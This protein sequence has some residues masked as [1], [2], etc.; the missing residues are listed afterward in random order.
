MSPVPDHPSEPGE[1]ALRLADVLDA[2]LVIDLTAAE[3]SQQ[4]FELA[5]RRLQE[6]GVIA[7]PAPVIAALT[8]R[9]ATGS[10]G[11]GHEVAL[12]HALVPLPLDR[13][14]VVLVRVRRGLDWHSADGKP[15]RLVTVIVASNE[16]SRRREYLHVLADLAR[17]LGGAHARQRCL[18]ARTA[19]AAVDALTQPSR[20][21]RWGSVRPLLILAAAVAAAYAGARLLM[22]AIHLPPG[23]AYGRLLHFN[24]PYWVSTQATVVAIFLGM[25]VGTLLF[26]K[27]RLAVVATGLA[28]L[29]LFN[30][31]PLPEMV[32]YMSLPTIIFVMAMMV[33][34]K[35]LEDKGVFRF[36]VLKTVERVGSTP[37]VLLLI[38][39]GFSVLLSGFVGEVSGILVTF[40]LAVEIARRTRTPVLPYLL[41]LVFATN[42]GSALTL[43][44]NPIGVYLA[45]VGGL[46]FEHFLR[47]ATPISLLTSLLVGAAIVLLFRRQLRTREK[48]S[49]ADM[50]RTMGPIDLSGLW[51][52]L[53]VFAVVVLMIVLHARLESLLRLG[54]GTML[55]VAPL[56][57]VVFIIFAEQEKAKALLAR[58]IDWWTLL[59]FMFLFASAACLEHT[60]VTTKLGYLVQ[61]AAEHSPL[62]RWLGPSGVTGS[63][64]TLILW[65]SGLSSGFVDNMP[66]VAALVPVVSSL[67]SV[68]MPHAQILYWALLFGGCF[69]GNLTMVGSSANLVAVGVY[70]RVT[71]QPIRFGEWFRTGLIVT[72]LSLIA[73][74]L[75]LLIQISLSP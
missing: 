27:F 50:E 73:A 30:V 8:A 55:V 35:W 4:V 74:T 19:Q 10:T 38:L 51:L 18:K 7:D 33:L 29:L 25:V 1:S 75:G 17:A 40:G 21:G 53:V 66:I 71:G 14:R 64:L 12:P 62:S 39:M 57:A 31:I 67:K 59:F 68:G 11:V 36:V 26:W 15:A 37:W 16:E 43:V 34:I 44:G 22:P 65:G 2:N 28:A 69:G 70:E 32:T 45:F 6:K 23:D 41:A 61:Q 58:S 52:G 56:A 20:P 54:E 47:W 3:S 49:L 42:I 63:A 24:E 46:T 48:L 5:A 9:E 13:P 72:V 60:G